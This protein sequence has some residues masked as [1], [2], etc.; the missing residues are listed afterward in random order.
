MSVTVHPGAVDGTVRAP[1]SKSVTHRALLLAML[2]G[3][4]SVRDPLWSADTL[5]TLGAV[6]A[7]GAECI[8]TRSE[9]VVRGGELTGAAIDAGNSGTTLRLATAIAATLP[10]TSR[11]SGDASLSKRPM[12]PLVEALVSLGAEA[13]CE[14]RNGRPPVTV[15]GPIEGGKATLPGDVSSQFVS[16]LLLAGPRCP[17]GLEIALSTP[18]ASAPYV[19]MTIGLMRGQG[20]TV[21][22]TEAGYAVPHQPIGNARIQVP[23]DYSAAAFPLVAGALTGGSV[24]VTN[25][26]PASGQ[27]DEALLDHLGAFGC[28]LERQDD[29]V[30][31]LGAELRPANVDLGDTPDLFPPLAV[32]AAAAPGKSRLH[33]APQLRIK[34]SDRIQ[35][36]CEG[37]AALSIDVVPT[38]DGATLEGGTVKGG[39]VASHG[40]HRIQMAFAVAA[41]AAESAITIEGPDDAHAVSYPA[42]LDHL[43]TLGAEV[44]ISETVLGVGR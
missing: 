43:R 29:A 7:F 28:S 24:T 22:E 1:G 34:E 33:G 23:G 41:L 5:A 40:D 44:D 12:G 14:G 37:L 39:V 11:L 9:A 4:G 17:K 42:F 2:G 16:G 32:L 30:T 27:G 31:L 35:A 3:G 21:E 36:M 19:A 6:R 18:L 15:T 13:A 25:L 8:A 26:P 10:G 20:L 38:E